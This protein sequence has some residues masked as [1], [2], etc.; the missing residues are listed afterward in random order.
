[1]PDAV[2]DAQVFTTW[3]EPKE[4][5]SLSGALCLDGL[6]VHISLARRDGS[7][8]GGHLAQGCIVNATA[9]LVLGELPQVEFRRPLNPDTGCHELSVQPARPEGDPGRDRAGRSPRA[10]ELRHASAARPRK[11]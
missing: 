9:E 2:G 11:A 1:M 4:I 10:A 6:H 3:V 5:L 7:C 8:I